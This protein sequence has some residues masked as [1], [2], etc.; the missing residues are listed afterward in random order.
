MHCPTLKTQI[1]SPEREREAG[2]ETFGEGEHSGEV[3]PV[4]ALVRLAGVHV[5]DVLAVLAL[6]GAA[7][8]ELALAL[9]DTLHPR[10][11]VAPTAAHDLTAVHPPGGLVAHPSCRAQRTCNTREEHVS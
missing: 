8:L 11:V 5:H 6:H 9:G 1:K 2:T 3:Q 10:C 7:P 4:G